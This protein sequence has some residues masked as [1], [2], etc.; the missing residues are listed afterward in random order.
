MEL[1]SD[2]HLGIFKKKKKRK[3]VSQL[4]NTHLGADLNIGVKM[5]MQ[6]CTVPFNWRQSLKICNNFLRTSVV[7]THNQINIL[8][9]H[10]YQARRNEL[11]ITHKPCQKI[12][13]LT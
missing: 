10:S 4:G 1:M 11:E 3:S 8:S 5:Q 12:K 7:R 2:C 13:K 6:S 9:H